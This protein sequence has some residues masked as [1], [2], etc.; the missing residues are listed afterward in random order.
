MIKKF[1]TASLLFS[2]FSTAAFSQNSITAIDDEFCA[3]NVVQGTNDVYNIYEND[4]GSGYW[5]S[6]GTVNSTAQG[7]GWFEGGG[8]RLFASNPD[9]GPFEVT[10]NYC[11]TN[12]TE[13]CANF[14]INV[15]DDCGPGG[16]NPETPTDGFAAVDDEFCVNNPVQGVNGLFDVYANDSGTNYWLTN[17]VF[18]QSPSGGGWFENEGL[19]LYLNDPDA[20]FNVTGNYTINNASGASSTATFAI[21]PCEIDNP[22]TR[23][24][25]VAQGQSNIQGSP[26]LSGPS[27]GL[28]LPENIA[29]EFR[30]DGGLIPYN[31]QLGGIGE[32]G[33]TGFQGYPQGKSQNHSVYYE[34][35]KTYHE[36]TG[37]QVIATPIYKGATAFSRLGSESYGGNYWLDDSWNGWAAGVEKVR[38][39]R[40][41]APDAEVNV[42]WYAGEYEMFYLDPLKGGNVSARKQNIKNDA[43]THINRMLNDLNA[44][45][46]YAANMHYLANSDRWVQ[47]GD[48]LAEILQELDTEMPRFEVVYDTRTNL[49]GDQYHVPGDYIH[50]GPNGLD[51]L[52]KRMAEGI[53]N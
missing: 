38:R 25:W 17:Y 48:L 52:G 4:S 28:T 45:M 10:G 21:T 41:A 5:F 24:I 20:D 34:F 19:R 7:G 9:A 35:A 50:L 16:E 36:L 11:I 23:E 32:W 40:E 26:L 27:Q 37:T 6:G 12:G 44:D 3:D 8:V 47:A 42:L 30:V 43:R 14:V 22:N 46:V 49:A 1:I 15:G 2:F 13:S 53:A 33:F 18:N 51:E 29:M 31:E 39:A